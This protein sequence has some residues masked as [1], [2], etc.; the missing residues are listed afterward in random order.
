MYSRQLQCF[1]LIMCIA[2]PGDI[3]LA[4]EA[5]RLAPSVMASHVR[6]SSVVQ[7]KHVG[8]AIT[9]KKRR[10]RGQQAI[11]AKRVREIQTALIREKYLEQPANGKWDQRSKQAM[12]RFQL[13]NHWQSKVVPD[14][15]ALIK[16]GLDPDYSDLI[17]P[18]TAAVSFIPGGGTMK[19]ATLSQH[20]PSCPVGPEL[21]QQPFCEG[22]GV[23]PAAPDR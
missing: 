6:P 10:K 18:D 9:R 15:R 20:C 1:A 16:L 3:A 21:N 22:A 17:N 12:A 2:V 19:S 7:G 4:G 14:S 13:D 8:K 5:K 23:A 11:D